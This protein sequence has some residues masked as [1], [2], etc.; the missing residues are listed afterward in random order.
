MLLP[1]HSDAVLA[2]SEP[3]RQWH[4]SAFHRHVTAAACTGMCVRYTGTLPR[5]LARYSRSNGGS[6]VSTMAATLTTMAVTCSGNLLG[7]HRHF[8]A[9]LQSAP[10]SAYA[11]AM[12]CPVLTQH[13]VLSAYALAMRCPVLSERMLL[14]AYTMSGTELAQQWR[15]QA[16]WSTPTDV[17]T[18]TTYE[19]SSTD[20]AYGPVLTERMA[21]LPGALD[22]NRIGVPCTQ[23]PV[24]YPPTRV[25]CDARY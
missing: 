10:L 9:L 14:P 5:L 7:N 2:G 8:H 23:A 1:G 6:A 24:R 18:S 11:P 22:V 4:A 20:G 21:L 19:L 3:G 16:R 25:L 12:R 17:S 13:R 15:C